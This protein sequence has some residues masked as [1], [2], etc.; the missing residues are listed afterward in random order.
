MDWLINTWVF[1][2]IIRP[3]GDVLLLAYLLYKSYRILVQTRAVQLLKGTAV[4]VAIWA[5]ALIFRLDTLTWILNLLVPG[6]VIGIAI[7]FQPELR[8][9]FTRLG[10]RE[11]LRVGSR[12]GAPHLETLLAALEQLSTRH[13]GALIVFPRA[14]GLRNIVQTGTPVDAEL[15]TG[16]LL[17]IFH[18][19]TPLH[20]G[21][22][23]VEGSRVAAAGCFLPLSEREDVQSV[24]GTRHRAALGL[25]E[26][27]DAVVVV[28]SEE[29]GA[30]SLA[31]D[32]DVRYDLSLP[33]I[34]SGLR[35]L[36]G[37]G[38]KREGPA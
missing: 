2:E 18:E 31:H 8:K 20:D 11:W 6:L 10:S 3:V 24:F 17:S 16:L 1:R 35:S 7:V 33:Q 37:F 30:V 28:V 19:G 9:I 5:V 27:T 14:V 38:A 12:Q 34:E 26:E 25:A 36:L 22:I 29:N 21:A 23:V 4:M 13:M 32:G 15:S